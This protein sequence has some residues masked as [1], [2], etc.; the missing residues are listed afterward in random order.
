MIISPRADFSCERHFNVAPASPAWQQEARTTGTIRPY[1]RRNCPQQQQQHCCSADA[2][3]TWSTV[4]AAS[5]NRFVVT[6]TAFKFSNFRAHCSSHV[7]VPRQSSN[8]LSLLLGVC[9]CLRLTLVITDNCRRM[10]ID[11]AH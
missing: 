7:P 1:A 8:K 2:V 6:V 10:V 9:L 5:R 11:N 4:H 3:V